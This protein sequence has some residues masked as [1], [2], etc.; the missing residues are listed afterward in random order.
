MRQAGIGPE[1]L[2]EEVE[3]RVSYRLFAA[4]LRDR[5][6]IKAHMGWHHESMKNPDV[7]TILER[8]A[9]ERAAVDEGRIMLL[10]A[11]LARLEAL[12]DSVVA[13]AREP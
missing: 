11:D 1:D 3:S 7:A 2:G 8:A 4:L 5:D 10:E 9:R 6:A 12:L 13:E